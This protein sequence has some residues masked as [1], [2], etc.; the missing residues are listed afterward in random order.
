[1]IFLGAPCNLTISSIKI[2][3]ISGALYVV[4]TGIKWVL[5]VDMST[6]TML[7]NQRHYI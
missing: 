2:Q 5:L 3:T 7:E 4:L 6:T 1:M